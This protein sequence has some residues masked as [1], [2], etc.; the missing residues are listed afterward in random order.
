MSTAAATAPVLVLGVTGKTG[1]AVAHALLALG[2]PVRGTSRSGAAA[3]DRVPAGVEVVDLDPVTGAGLDEALAGVRAIH[4]SA[5]NLFA[6]EV[7]MLERT[8]AAAR[9]AG[10]SR[11][12]FHS[13]MHPYAP[14]MPHHLRKAQAE[15]LLRTSGLDWT[16]LQPAAYHQNLLGGLPEG[17]LAW[18]YS[19]D[20]TFSNVDLRDVAQAS[21]EVLVHDGHVHAT[22]ELAGPEELDAHTMAAQAGEVLGIDVRAERSEPPTIAGDLR[23]SAE[24]L[25]MFAHYDAH[26]FVGS[27]RALTQLLGRRP[28]TWQQAVTDLAET[29][30]PVRGR[31]PR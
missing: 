27:P 28:T 9:R 18:P 2:V 31:H 13:V 25:A 10:V 3:L 14:N 4:H 6:D 7:G 11:V 26:G 30:S 12:V 5:P 29:T 21:A 16:I 23:A 22:Y 17:R 1:A 15:H 19:L 8:V 24:L 20:R